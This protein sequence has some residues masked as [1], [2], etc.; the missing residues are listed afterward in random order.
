M[1]KTIADRIQQRMKELG[2]SQA[3]L[4][5]L[6]K[7]GRASVNGWIHG[8]N[9]P[10]AKKIGALAESLQT[11]TEWL[12]T[13]ED[14]VILKAEHGDDN[15]RLADI[16]VRAVPIIGFTQAGAWREALNEP[17]G[18]TYSTYPKDGLFSLYV[19]G[20]SMEPLF[21]EGDLLIIDPMRVP[22]PSDY[23]IAQNGDYETTFKKYRVVDYDE[24][25]QE[26]F[27]LVPLNQDYPILRSDRRPLS[28][29]GVVVE[30]VQRF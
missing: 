27:E 6:T 17:L 12:L 5:R 3:D 13:G 23:V 22:K 20:D 8:H 25:G 24:N 29:I 15:V 26:I 11:T 18:V 10:S 2:I 9:E 30:R 28:I 14:R 21:H 7:A 4:I 1:N 16:R 19:E